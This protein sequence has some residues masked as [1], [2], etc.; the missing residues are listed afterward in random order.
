MFT[1]PV[2]GNQGSCLQFG[3]KYQIPVRLEIIKKRKAWR[4]L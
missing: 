4:E 3:G 2:T 1:I